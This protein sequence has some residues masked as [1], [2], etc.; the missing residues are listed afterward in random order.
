MQIYLER[1]LQVAQLA[2]FI[3]YPE[4][5]IMDGYAIF[6]VIAWA[7]RGTVQ[8]FIAGFLEHDLG[9][10]KEMYWVHLVFDDRHFDYIIKINT[11]SF[12]AGLE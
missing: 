8:Y 11:R 9:K 5:V 12:H 4:V 7:L 3:T 6:W 2:R 10:L 1:K